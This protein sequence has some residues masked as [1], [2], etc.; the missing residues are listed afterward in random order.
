[1]LL[2]Q[3][4]H[5]HAVDQAVQRARHRGAFAGGMLRRTVQGVCEELLC[6][7]GLPD[8]LI[9]LIDLVADDFSPLGS[10]RI[11]DRGSCIE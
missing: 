4:S 3:L 9:E 7:S 5:T 1:M 10:G 6:T 8:H 2:G 11:E